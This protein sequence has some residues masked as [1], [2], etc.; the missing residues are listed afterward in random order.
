[1]WIA[2]L[3]GSV[4]LSLLPN[5]PG[6]ETLHGWLPPLQAIRAFG[7]AGQMALV[8]VAVLASFGV[9]AMAI[10]WPRHQAAIGLAIL[11]LV[12]LE[13]LRAP[14][15]WAEFKGVDPVYRTLTTAPGAIAEMPMFSPRDIFG[16]ARYMVNATGHHRPII[17]G[18]SGFMPPSY[19]ANYEALRSFPDLQALQRLHALGVTHVVVHRDWYPPERV[20]EIERSPGLGIVARSGSIAIFRVLSIG[21]H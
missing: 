10:R 14:M 15:R 5:V 21:A 6:F 3:G 7:R 1:M 9:A 19:G 2:V 11:A 13:A 4:A 17:N 8:A 20:E 18:Y 16:N 12:N